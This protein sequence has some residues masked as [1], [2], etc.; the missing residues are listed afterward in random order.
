MFYNFVC[1]Q[2]YFEIKLDGH[3]FY[4]FVCDQPYFEIILVGRVL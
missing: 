3:M 4:N 1:D 2:P